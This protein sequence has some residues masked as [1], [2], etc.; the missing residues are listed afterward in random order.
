[1]IKIRLERKLLY[2]FAFFMFSYIRDIISL[3]IFIFFKLKQSY[4]YPFLMTLGQIL[5][6]AI[7]YFYQKRTLKQEK[8][9]EYFQIEFIVNEIELKQKDKNY[10]IILLLFFASFFDFIEFI[11]LIFYFSKYEDVPSTK[12]SRLGCFSI[13]SSSLICTY[14]L[15]F[16][17]GKHHKFSM[18]M[19]GICLILTISL[20]L[21]YNL[22]NISIV[23][24]IFAYFLIIFFHTNIS[25]TDCIERYLADENYKNPFIII[26]IEGIFEFFFSSLYCIGN[27][28][29]KPFKEIKYQYE[30]NDTG[31]F[32]L[33][34]FFF[35]L[36]LLLSAGLNVYKIY[37]NVTFSPMARSF[38]EFLLNPFFN[39]YYFIIEKDFNQ[40]YLYFFIDEIICFII[41]FFACVYNEYIILNCFG[42]EYDT[43]YE[44]DKRAKKISSLDYILGNDDEDESNS[45]L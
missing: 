21:I 32:I 27:I 41:D 13:I 34:I 17:L 12:D 1:M 28:G 36:Y 5:G 11:I 22:P 43:K 23:K 45:I 24:F 26:M 4:I 6:G 30:Q 3:L 37:V 29:N 44:I 39:I 20:E 9:V 18:I 7:I 40:N 25:F 35:F 8:K 31:K 33:L 2:V 42:L 14:A 16:K 15:R 10:K 38:M 19:L